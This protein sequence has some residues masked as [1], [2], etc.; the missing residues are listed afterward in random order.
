MGQEGQWPLR[1]QRGGFVVSNIEMAVAEKLQKRAAVGLGKYGVTMER[2]DLSRLDWLIHAQE[3]AMDLAVYL[4]RL[5]Q[6]LT[7][8]KKPLDENCICIGSWVET[9]N[10]IDSIRGGSVGRVVEIRCDPTELPGFL[11]RIWCDSGLEFWMNA[12]NLCDATPKV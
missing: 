11:F 10:S 4:E 2:T 9:I 6:D 12:K 3:E 8:I 1:V 5:I 7:N